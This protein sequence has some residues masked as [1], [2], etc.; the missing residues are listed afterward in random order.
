MVARAKDAVDYR[1]V[2]RQQASVPSYGDLSDLDLKNALLSVWRHK[3][4]VLWTM[5]LCAFVAAAIVLAMTPMYSATVTFR[6]LQQKHLTFGI[7]W[8][9]TPSE[10]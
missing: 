6:L 7:A 10:D 8:L 2:A 5:L 4:I 9:E 3:G 1:L